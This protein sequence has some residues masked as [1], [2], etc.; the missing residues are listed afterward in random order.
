MPAQ[1][2]R[3]RASS[4]TR[5]RRLSLLPKLIVG[6]TKKQPDLPE[7]RGQGIAP[8]WPLQSDTPVDIQS[9][10]PSF[11]VDGYVASP[12]PLSAQSISPSVFHVGNPKKL[13]EPK[14]T[15]R[16][17]QHTSWVMSLN[18][19]KAA[20]KSSP[21]QNVV[22]DLNAAHEDLMTAR[23]EA[24]L[25]ALQGDKADIFRGGRP[26]RSSPRVLSSEGWGGDGRL[27]AHRLIHAQH[28][29][30]DR[31]RGRQPNRTSI[32]Q[33]MDFC[34]KTLGSR[35]PSR[36][37]PSEQ[38]RIVTHHATAAP[39]PVLGSVVTISCTEATP[40]FYTRNI[41]SGPGTT[42]SPLAVPTIP[43]IPA[44]TQLLDPALLFFVPHPKNVTQQ[45]VSG[46]ETTGVEY[47]KDKALVPRGAT[48]RVPPG[49]SYMYAA[50][51]LEATP[52][53]PC[54]SDPPSK[55]S[56]TPVSPLEMESRSPLTELGDTALT[57]ESSKGHQRSGISRQDSASSSM[58]ST[59]DDSSTLVGGG[60]EPAEPVLR[61]GIHKE[62]IQTTVYES[63]IKAHI[64]V[65]SSPT[66]NLAC[67]AW[68]VRSRMFQ[69]GC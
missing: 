59:D 43:Q 10:Y 38:G 2:D 27:Q 21:Q 55:S 44:P 1:P 23:M 18:P 58:Y 61:L 68:L 48:L 8:E 26:T 34:S 50:F 28:V 4:G 52:V 69:L 46:S 49:T 22:G 30:I 37:E 5:L 40:P 11:P 63:A 13:H 31:G 17:S 29:P 57:V 42:T 67:D 9:A 39:K 24:T 6:K 53:S 64:F 62:P 16:R 54:G 35:L 14:Q 20:T 66:G 60:E 47:N 15:E 51:E 3:R 45:Q 65:K 19:R 12:R 33:D 41:S 25:S 36:L 32:H 7:S 56:P